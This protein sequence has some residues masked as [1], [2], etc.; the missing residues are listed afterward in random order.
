MP[1][2]SPRERLLALLEDFDSAMLVTRACDGGLHA[3]PMAVAELKPDGD[4]YFVTSLQS[5]KITEIEQ[6]PTVTVTFQSSAQFVAV[7]GMARIDRDRSLIE[8]LWSPAWKAWFP[9]GKDDPGLVVIRVDAAEAEYWDNA[10]AQAVKYAW[11]ATK[12]LV[13]GKTPELDEKQHAKVDL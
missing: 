4:L 11:E 13:Q 9:R 8:R 6:D 2:A 7:S 12:S 5:P 10:G 1:S 3:R